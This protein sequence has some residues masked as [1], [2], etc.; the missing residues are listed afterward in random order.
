MTLA[1]LKLTVARTTGAGIPTGTAFLV[2][3]THALTCAHCVRTADN[4]IVATLELNFS[5]VRRKITAA[6]DVVDEERDVALLRL[7]APVDLAHGPRAPKPMKGVSWEA[8]GYPGPS[9]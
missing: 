7:P 5:Q 3:P 9:G 2:S 4:V 8:F 6:V 1:E